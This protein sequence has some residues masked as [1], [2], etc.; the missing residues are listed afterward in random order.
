MHPPVSNLGI[1]Q[2]GAYCF[3]TKVYGHRPSSIKSLSD[4]VKWFK[5]LKVSS[6]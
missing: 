2:M 6:F 4:E 1:F 5:T 3:A